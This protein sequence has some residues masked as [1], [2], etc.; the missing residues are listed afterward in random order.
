[1]EYKKKV[2]P[3]SELNDLL[4]KRY[5]NKPLFERVDLIAEKI[6]NSYFKGTKG[7]FIKIRSHLLKIANFTSDMKKYI[8]TFTLQ[9]YF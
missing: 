7:D 5:D 2:I 9:L 1:M 3:M 4:Y 8:K 6:N